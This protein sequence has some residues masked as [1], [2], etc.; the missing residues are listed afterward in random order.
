MEA[1]GRA[2]MGIGRADGERRAVRAAEEAIVCPLLEQSNI[3]GAT[4]VIVNIRGGRDI[5]M[6]EVEEAVTTVKK[7]AH[8]DARIIFGAVVEEE[9]Q[10]ELQVMVIAAGFSPEAGARIA[11]RDRSHWTEDARREE[12]KAP[13]VNANE[14]KPEPAIAQVTGPG[15]Q[16]EFLADQE[17]ILEPVGYP[18]VESAGP[19]DFER[20]T[21]QR[22]Q[23]EEEDLR[24]PS[25]L[26]NRK[27]NK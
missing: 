19:D 25:F 23:E 4:G 9:E 26:R 22:L 14:A 6:R 18:V 8:P 24:I 12:K 5:G 27:K 20:P 17:E 1:G 7:A 16:T 11:I 13:E 21:H 2:L 10:P 15:L 3:N